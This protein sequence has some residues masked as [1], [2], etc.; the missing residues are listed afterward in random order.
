MLIQKM[1]SLFTYG[2]KNTVENVCF[3]ETTEQISALMKY[4]IENVS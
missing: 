1:K 4:A 3:G 2:I